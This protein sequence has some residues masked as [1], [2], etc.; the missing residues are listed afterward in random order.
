MIQ[1]IVFNETMTEMTAGKS[2]LI[3]AAG[4]GYAPQGTQS[5]A[6]K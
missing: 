4:C 2:C 3:K 1:D 5:Q 6:T